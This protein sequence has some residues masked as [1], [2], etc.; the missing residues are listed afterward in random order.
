[1]RKMHIVLIVVMISLSVTLCQAQPA[2]A[3]TDTPARGEAPVVVSPTSGTIVGPAT[4]VV[5]KAYPGSLVVIQT[6]VYD[7]NHE[8]EYYRI[9][10][11]HRHRTNPDGSFSLL[12]STPRVFFGNRVK[13]HYDIHVFTATKDGKESPH[14]VIP[15]QQKKPQAQ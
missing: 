2:A 4:L 14:T 9:I 12:V 11:G 3:P 10:P 13:L 8:N 7:E 6:H 1:M 15:V 5:G